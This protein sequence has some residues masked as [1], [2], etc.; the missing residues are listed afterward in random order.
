MFGPIDI[1]VLN[2]PGPSPGAAADMSADD[3]RSAFEQLIE[4]KLEGKEVVTPPPPGEAKV[5]DLA[6]AL[7]RS[8]RNAR[9]TA[10]GR[11]EGKEGPAA[12]SGASRRKRKAP[13]ARRR[14]ASA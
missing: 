13:P 12:V 3:A 14:R 7:A 1:L 6:D 2:G 4:A 11:N 9:S 8:V 5:I 10:A